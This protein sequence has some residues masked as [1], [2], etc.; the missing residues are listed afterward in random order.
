VSR[1]RP[2]AALVLVA[3]ALPACGGDDDDASDVREVRDVV[4]RFAQSSDARA[5][6]LFTDEYVVELYGGT[7]Q[8]GPPSGSAIDRAKANCRR[9]SGSFRSARIDI[10]NAQIVADHAARVKALD[11]RGEVEYNVLLRKPEGEDDWLIDQ[12]TKKAVPRS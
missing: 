2:A 1:R 8:G 11:P 9:R 12:I 6:E 7:G 10:E 3:L 4:N 5:C